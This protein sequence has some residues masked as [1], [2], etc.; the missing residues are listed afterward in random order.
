MSGRN[1]KKAIDLLEGVAAE[2][3]QIH[4]PKHYGFWRQEAVPRLSAALTQIE[5]FSD[6]RNIWIYTG[7]GGGVAGGPRFGDWA[8]DQLVQKKLPEA[9]MA[10]FSA[11]LERNVARYSDVSPIFGVQINANCDLG[12]GVTLVSGPGEELASILHRLPFQSIRLPT[13]TALLC[14]TFAVTPA[15]ERGT[16]EKIAQGVRS[17]TAPEMSHRSAVRNHVRLACLLASAGPVELPLTVQRAERGALFVAGD[18]NLADRPFTA[19]PLVSYPVEASVVTRAFELIG[20]FRE[21]ESFTRA[22]DR[23]GRARLAA[24]PVDR[25]LEL[26][27]AAEIALMHDHSPANSEITHKIGSRAAWLLGRDP[28]DRKAVFIEMKKLY[29]ARSQAVHAGILSTKSAVDLDVA[30]RLVA[31]VLYAILERG[32]FPNWNDLTMG[33]SGKAKGGRSTPEE[34]ARDE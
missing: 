4:R 23:L 16:G 14:Q 13:G 29:Q 18:G 21:I 9:V 31:R 26:G 15:F 6:V 30:D 33:D 7:D 3:A 12:S 1:Y 22:V 34:A 8:I 5:P 27:I 17:I 11:E 2:L 10:A 19:R 20:K 32:G 24:S 28:G 25:A